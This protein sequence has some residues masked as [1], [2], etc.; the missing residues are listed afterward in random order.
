MEEANLK[1]SIRVD[2]ED[3]TFSSKSCMKTEIKSKM[4]TKFKRKGPNRIKTQN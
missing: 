3:E 2:I 4:E 1:F